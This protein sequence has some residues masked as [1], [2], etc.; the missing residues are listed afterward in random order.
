M[1]W[2]GRRLESLGKPVSPEVPAGESWEISD[3]PIH[4][5]VVAA[6][7]WKGSTLADLVVRHPRELFGAGAPATFPWLVKF[8]DA[9]DWLSV[10]VH[11]DAAAAARLCPKEGPKNEVWFVIDAAPE[12]A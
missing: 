11:P 1:V 10:Q 2:G 3:H 5:S 9:Q 8:L 6:G 7:A 4:R 12:S